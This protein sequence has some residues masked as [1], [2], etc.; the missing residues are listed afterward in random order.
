VFPSLDLVRV[1]AWLAS[2]RA[3]GE[4]FSEYSGPIAVR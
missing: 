4:S 3:A 2:S 1:H